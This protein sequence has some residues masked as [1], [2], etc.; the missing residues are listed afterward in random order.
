METEEQIVYSIIETVKKGN[1]TD[2]NRINE[3]LIRAFLKKYRA[4]SIAKRSSMGLTITDECFQYLG[5][6]K[7]DYFKSRQ[8]ERVL[9][10]MILLNSNF[11]IRMEILGENIPVLNSE[12]YALSLKTLLNGKLPKAK[13]TGSKATIYVGEYLIINGKS[14]PKK[15]FIIDEF[16]SQIALNSNSHIEVEVYGV[17]D[18]P[19]HALDYDWTSTPFPCSSE[20][21]EEIT[22]KILAKEFN[23]ILNIKADKITDSDDNDTFYP[24]QQRLR[25][26]GD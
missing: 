25:N 17:L 21:I 2:D 19:D 11:G 1:L 3:R 14:K 10:K 23:L 24:Q 22:Y 20:L 6:L 7:F 5:N 18:N 12:E 13:L 9:P 15:N 8:F 4:S 26:Q 16:K